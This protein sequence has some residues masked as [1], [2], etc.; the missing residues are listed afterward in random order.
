MTFVSVVPV[1]LRL[2]LGEGG[3]AK[4]YPLIG[5]DITYSGLGINVC[6]CEIAVGRGRREGELPAESLVFQRNTAAEL[7]VFGDSV[8]TSGNSA[9]LPP[10][11]FVVF[12]GYVDVGGPARISVGRF[13]AQ[14]VLR[15]RLMKLDSGTLQ[16]STI[17][18]TSFTDLSVDLTDTYIVGDP[19]TIRDESFGETL[20]KTLIKMADIGP[21]GVSRNDALANIE[22]VF[23]DFEANTEAAELLSSMKMYL[24][25]Q[26]DLVDGHL[27]TL[28]NMYREVLSQTSRLS[29]FYHKMMAL[30]TQLRFRVLEL[31][32]GI[33]VVPYTPLVP[34]Q[35]AR[36]IA[37]TTYSGLNWG[38]E[39]MS[40][41]QGCV[42][43]GR[44]ANM[45]EPTIVGA[46]KR[47]GGS[48]RIMTEMAPAICMYGGDLAEVSAMVKAIP[49]DGREPVFHKANLG[50]TMAR[51]I[52]LERIYGAR[53]MTVSVPYFRVDIGPLTSIRVTY[54]EVTDQLGAEVYGSVQQVRISIDA[55]AKTAT[56]TYDVGYVRSYS[57]QH[58]DID[59]GEQSTGANASQATGF[60]HPIWQFLL[61]GT[62]LD[63][64]RTTP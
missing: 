39:G 10:D 53:Q 45:S 59:V 20:K 38:Y 29:S 43:L 21:A 4:E 63:A 49:M 7:S 31:P 26:K 15:G 12:R 5:A 6:V 13:S 56:T 55:T 11:G 22:K 19:E 44:G 40:Q 25:L 3:T 32:S 28:Y 30:G 14:V 47:P 42:L 41:Y 27:V 57:E 61:Y 33:H 9:N 46:Y 34:S 8:T 35:Y 23:G 37:P 50:D 17:V 36:T 24:D 51:H 18:P 2:K 1:R 48:G 62:S 58:D 54:P 64:I 52:C 60:S 16:T